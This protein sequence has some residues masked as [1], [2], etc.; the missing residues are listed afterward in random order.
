MKCGIYMIL[1]KINNKVYIGQSIDIY[2]RWKQHRA[3]L[4]H[5]NHENKHLENAWHKYGEKNFEFS[6]LCECEEEQLNTIEQYYILCFES[7]N[8]KIGYNKDYGGSAGRPP[9]Y[10]RDKISNSLKG[11]TP[12]NK[13]IKT[14]HTP[15]NKGKKYSNPK[16]SYSNKGKI[17]WNRVKIVCLNTREVFESIEEAG[18]KYNLPNANIHKNL[19]LKINSCG[20]NDKGEPLVWRY[21]KDYLNMSKEEISQILEKVKILNKGGNNPSAKKVI[22]LDTLEVFNSMRE[23][24]IKYDIYKGGV[25]E[26]CKNNKRVGKIKYIFMKYEEYLKKSA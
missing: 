11:H 23:A 20:K 21:Y 2:T 3:D 15:W 17:A 9:Q 14:G 6:I 4:R 13:G 19:Q 12:W 7:I 25:C 16:I 8:P 10:V 24:E 1:N 22:C 5:K 18:R 26:S